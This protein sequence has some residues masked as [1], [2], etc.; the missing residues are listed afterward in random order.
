M[1]ARNKQRQGKNKSNTH[2]LAIL[3]N[4][5]SSTNGGQISFTGMLFSCPQLKGNAVIYNQFQNG[6]KFTDSQV[7]NLHNKLCSI[8]HFILD[9]DDVQQEAALLALEKPEEASSWGWIESVLLTRAKQ[10]KS[11]KFGIS[12]DEEDEDSGKY[13]IDLIAPSIEDIEV[14]RQH[15]FVIGVDDCDL[16]DR[17]ELRKRMGVTDRRVRQKLQAMRENLAVQNDLFMG[18]AA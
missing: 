6:L 8:G 7:K 14:W 9:C 17:A 16:E 3:F 5:K 12:I 2:D 4:H 15:D 13:A 1:Q 11:V 18:V 10:N